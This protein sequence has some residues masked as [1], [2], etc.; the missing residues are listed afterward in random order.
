MKRLLSLAALSASL[1]L[2]PAPARACSLCASLQDQKTF[3]EDAALS[4]IILYGTFT[5]STAGSSDFEITTKL[6]TDAVLGD[7][8]TLK[9]PKYVPVT[10]AKNPP[11]Y[12]LFADVYKGKPDYFRGTLVKSAAAADYVKGVA[13]IDPKDRARVLRYCFDFLENSDPEIANDAFLE[14]AK[15]TDKEL[16][17]VGPKLAPEKLRGWLKSDAKTPDNRLGLYAFLLGACGGDADAAIFRK[18][19]DEPT[20]RTK[21]AFDGILGGYIHLRPKEGWDAAL[22][23]LQDEKKPFTVR[24]AAIRTLRFYHNWKPEESK[25][26]VMRGLKVILAQTDLADMAVED[27]RRWQIFDLTP[28]VLALYGKKGFD[29]PILRQAIIR[30]ALSCPKSDKEVAA[31]LAERRKQDPDL[32]KDAEDALQFLKQK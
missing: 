12:L 29:A 19:I 7:A 2:V 30:Y 23:I 1:V 27:L 8:T 22:K 26:N 4:K 3:R 13:A 9:I 16:G 28:D 32:V 25:E 20:E 10:D 21:A 31:F 17:E 14:F 15:A 6:K 11:R 18:L 24:F 5:G